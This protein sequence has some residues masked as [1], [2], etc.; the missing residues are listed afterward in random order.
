MECF[1]NWIFFQQDLLGLQQMDKDKKLHF[2]TAMGD[3]LQFTDE[4]FDK[5]I[6]PFLK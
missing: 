2:L 6:L 3:H 5:E 4:F 1:S